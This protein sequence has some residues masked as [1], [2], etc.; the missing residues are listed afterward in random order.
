MVPYP[1]PASQHGA[2][3]RAAPLLFYLSF[4]SLTPKPI[5][6]RV[7]PRP[8]RNL[9]VV[10]F[11]I[12]DPVRFFGVCIIAGTAIGHLGQAVGVLDHAWGIQHP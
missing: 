10:V 5:R 4:C 9:H 3:A 8:A 7:G 1:R 12:P 2:T 6:P 11:L